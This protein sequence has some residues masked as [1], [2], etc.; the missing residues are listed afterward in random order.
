MAW[1]EKLPSGKWRGGYI[2]RNGRKQQLGGFGVRKHALNWA[3]D[4]EQAALRGEDYTARAGR[5][6]FREFAE[7][8]QAA[9]VVERST[10][11][12][13]RHRY[14]VII[15]RWGD[16]PIGAIGVLEL[17]AWV[18]E[19]Q[20]QMAAGTVRKYHGLMSSI[21]TAATLPPQRLITENPAR[22]VRLPKVPRGRE[23]Y[24]THEQV[25]ALDVAGADREISQTLTWFLPYTGFRLGEALGLHLPRINWLRRTVAAVDVIG[26]TSEGFHHQEYTKGDS[27]SWSPMRE[28]PLVKEVLN[29]MSEHVRN[30]PPIDCGLHKDC[31]GLVFWTRKYGREPVPI[32][33]QTYS[34]HI[35]KPAAAAAKLPANV[36]PH[37]LRHTYASW[38]VQAGVSLHE[39]QYLLGH[40][41]IR[42]T[43]RY[44]HHAPGVGDAA[45]LALEQR[46]KSRG[47]TP[48]KRSHE[49][50]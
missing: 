26:H 3:A 30:Y 32:L 49:G 15:D 34:R 18:K 10:A 43:E 22:H 9:R 1:V 11:D 20:Q 6:P 19:L 29:R 50:S 23:V 12:R 27:D 39:V 44:A 47:N 14:D 48:S 31:S 8:W 21:L 4:G 16:V 45:R 2:D 40:E 37:D 28:V 41:S 17:Q 42:T 24:L 5:T 33:G 38:L 46:G 36:R 35:F 7:R 25:D 13:E